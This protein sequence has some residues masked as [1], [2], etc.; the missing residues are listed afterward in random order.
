[1]F[2]VKYV[3]K[4]VKSLHLVVTEHEGVMSHKG[5]SALIVVK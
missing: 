1:M 4:I 2:W 5:L 3:N